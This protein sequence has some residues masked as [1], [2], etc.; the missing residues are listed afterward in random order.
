[1]Q[2]SCCDESRNHSRTVS[3]I[4]PG[5]AEKTLIQALTLSKIYCSGPVHMSSVSGT[6]HQVRQKPARFYMAIMGDF[7]PPSETKSTIKFS[8]I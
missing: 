7:I 4:S 2:N 3:A 1:M 8:S 6:S 5:A